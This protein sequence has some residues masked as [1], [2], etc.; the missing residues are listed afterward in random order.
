M[1]AMLIDSDRKK[2]EEID[3]ENDLD[4]MY[5][6]L[7]TSKV[8]VDMI[9]AVPIGIKGHVIYVDEEGKLKK[10]WSGFKING[11]VIA[12]NG[13]VFGDD[14][15]GGDFDCTI[16]DIDVV[17][18]ISFV[19]HRTF[20]WEDIPLGL[21]HYVSNTGIEN[22]RDLLNSIMP[23]DVVWDIK[24]I[25]AREE[26]RMNISNSLQ[27]IR[28]IPTDIA[29]FIAEYTVEHHVRLLEDVYGKRERWNV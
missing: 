4:S 7:S 5:R 3:I 17:M 1:K 16:T 23:E 11:V 26:F 2:V 20:H 15:Q 28:G 22:W 13:L 14:G 29:E 8:K 18:N 27:L 24:E 21:F 6:A 10:N 9:E 25:K 19:G 12:G